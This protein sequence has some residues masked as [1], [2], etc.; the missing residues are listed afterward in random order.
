MRLLHTTLIVLAAA[1]CV[2]P[3]VLTLNVAPADAIG[4]LRLIMDRHPGDQ[5]AP[6]AAFTMGRLFQEKLPAQ[7]AEAYA[8]ARALAPQ[9]PLAEDALAR[10]VE[11]WAAAHRPAMAMAAARV[12]LSAYPQGSRAALVR[13]LGGLE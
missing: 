5:R 2:P 13:R 3:T 7:A 6:L 12:Y 11:S 9:G 1:G 4:P 8:Q 10:E